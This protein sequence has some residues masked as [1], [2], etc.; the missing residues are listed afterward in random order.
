MPVA[1]LHQLRTRQC[2]SV[3][4]AAT[5]HVMCFNWSTSRLSVIL[6]CH[7][8][9]DI[10]QRNDNPNSTSQ[11]SRPIG[12][13]HA[14]IKSIHNTIVEEFGD[15]SFDHSL[16]EDL[17]ETELHDMHSHH[18][19]AVVDLEEFP[20]A[21]GMGGQE[22]GQEA[23]GGQQISW[24]GETDLYNALN[25]GWGIR[26]RKQNWSMRFSRLHKYSFIWWRILQLHDLVVYWVLYIWK[27][28]GLGVYY[29][30]CHQIPASQ[31]PGNLKMLLL[32]GY[33]LKCLDINIYTVY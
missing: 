27:L 7:F 29:S 33:W 4:E 14:A 21:T 31:E 1:P 28:L 32:I 24:V 15:L 11:P 16:R 20:W 2:P 22:V 18:T 12:S 26:M 5:H 9:L 3:P 17:Q 23:S 6:I 25:A 13:F 8:L 30:V 19:E 10:R